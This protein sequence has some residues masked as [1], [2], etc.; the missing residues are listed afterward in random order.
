MN[1]CFRMRQWGGGLSA[2]VFIEN[3]KSEMSS[4]IVP[5]QRPLYLDWFSKKLFAE[6][7]M[8]R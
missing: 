7:K 3:E 4:L 1:H 6:A 5:G 2:I 8:N